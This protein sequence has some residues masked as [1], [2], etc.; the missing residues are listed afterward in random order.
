MGRTL[1]ALGRFLESLDFVG[2]LA[3]WMAGAPISD[4]TLTPLHLGLRISA[5]ADRVEWMECRLG[6]RGSGTGGMER[7]P[8]QEWRHKEVRELAGR[9]EVIDWVY[10][11]PFGER[12]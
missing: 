1:G 3:C 12:R 7:V 10:K 6:K 5:T 4:Q 2:V 8:W 11:I 9:K